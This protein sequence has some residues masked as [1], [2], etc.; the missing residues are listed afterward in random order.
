[1]TLIKRFVFYPFSSTTT[2]M[3][4]RSGKRITLIVGFSDF[5]GP[6]LN[7]LTRL[8]SLVRLLCER[9]VVAR[10]SFRLLCFRPMFFP[11]RESQK[12]NEELTTELGKNETRFCRAIIVFTNIR[13]CI[14]LI[15]MCLVQ[16][17]IKH[18]FAMP[19]CCVTH[20]G[21]KSVKI[22]KSWYCVLA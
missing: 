20:L 22:Y 9:S 2:T 8:M 17:Q 12:R 5:C 15:V 18:I 14:F 16:H 3:A 1:M 13:W 7:H 4:D 11:G 6:P 21:K 10:A 19:N